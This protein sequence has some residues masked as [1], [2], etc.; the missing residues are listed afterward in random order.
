MPRQP[1]GPVPAPTLTIMVQ[2]HTK[3][4]DPLAAALGNASLL[5]AGYLLLGRRRL[6]VLTGLV[7]IALVTVLALAVRTL[8]F[9]IVVLVWWAALAAHGWH[10]ARRT[11]RPA[12]A[13]RQRLTGLAVALPVLLAVGLLRFDAARIEGDAI[14]AHGRGDCP[15]ALAALDGLWAGHAV[16]DAP[17]TARTGDTVRACRLLLA[18]E[19]QLG[20]A[21]GGDPANLERAFATLA[22]VRAIPGQD[23]R[24]REVLD[25]FTGRLPVPDPCGTA[26]ITD[27]LRQGARG[28]V[29][30]HA[31]GVVPRVAPAALAG[32]ADRLMAADDW[33]RARDR[34]QQILD[35]YPGH[36]LTARAGD[37]VTRAT[38]A[39]EL[40]NVRDLLEV[41]YPGA[42]P[43]YCDHPAPY[44]GAAPYG[45]G[46]NRALVFGDDEHLGR[47]PAE[48]RAGGPADAVAV[49]C[50]GTTDYGAEVRSCPYESGLS[51]YGY[52]DVSFRK[53]AIPVRVYEVKTGRLVTDTRVEIGGASCPPVL[54]YTT[55]V[56]LAV[57]IPPSQVYVTP[58]DADVRAAFQPLIDP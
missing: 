5:G 44:S 1:P 28:P 45:D 2:P 4:A 9:E 27:W 53:I 42:E 18:A 55:Y 32:C 25:R 30:D 8:S 56:D 33:P 36:E 48:W 37:G 58:S 40:A 34:Y 10:L 6:A 22:D 46:P 41:S 29:L 3:A 35:Q 11:E 12:R 24:I 7:T 21:L 54:H 14:E 51:L 13:G 49:I 50:A 57:D 38:Q 19:A 47:F 52:Q 16:A 26:A 43:E 17:L 15:G 20:K 23:Q 39:I 31:A